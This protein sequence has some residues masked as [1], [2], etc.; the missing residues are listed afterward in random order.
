[1]TAPASSATAAAGSAEPR[2]E[3]GKLGDPTAAALCGVGVVPR[4]TL[5][6]KLP[7]SSTACTVAVCVPG[8]T[9]SFCTVPAGPV[10]G[11]YRAAPLPNFTMYD[12]TVPAYQSSP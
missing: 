7:S 8:G 5:G 1:M 12:V 6:P 10:G 3:P 4:L 11:T 9:A 2:P